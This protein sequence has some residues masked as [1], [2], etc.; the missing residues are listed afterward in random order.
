M[1]TIVSFDD[2]MN[3]RFGGSED[4]Y[5]ELNT[6]EYAWISGTDISKYYW[7]NLT[8]TFVYD[9]NARRA[10]IYVNG[11]LMSNTLNGISNNSFP[12]IYLPRKHFIKTYLHLD[13]V[14]LHSIRLWN[15]ALGANEIGVDDGTKPNATFALP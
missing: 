6:E 14:E 15:R 3:V 11:L 13:T 7:Q 8:F 10:E 12:L 2:I 5:L 4:V 9:V 1:Q